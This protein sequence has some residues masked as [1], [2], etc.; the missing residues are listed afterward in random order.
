MSATCYINA[1]LPILVM[2]VL[3]GRRSAQPAGT[4]SDRDTLLAIKKDWGE[5]RQLASWDPATADHC[6]WSG[7]TCETAGG[8]VGGVV[9]EFSLSVRN[10]N[11]SVP[12]SMCALK[13]LRRL[14]LSY[15]N[16]TGAFPAAAL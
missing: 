16:I 15:N 5:P 7:V 11:G 6:R 4:P 12:A 14:D 2:L 1:V 3:A 8:S 13:N 10:L 9:V